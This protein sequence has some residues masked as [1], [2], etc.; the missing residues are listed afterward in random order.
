MSVKIDKEIV[1]YQVLNN[2]EPQ[3]EPILRN[4]NNG[5]ASSCR[6]RTLYRRPQHDCRVAL[7]REHCSCCFR[8]GTNPGT[9]RAHLKQPSH[10][11]ITHSPQ[12]IIEQR[13]Q[14]F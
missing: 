4:N 2:K 13:Q 6:F 3:Q 14:S 12:T 7:F 5:F 8:Q 11:S 1:G 10:S 9:K